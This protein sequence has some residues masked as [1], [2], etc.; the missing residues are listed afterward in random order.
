M[1]KH[2]YHLFLIAALVL[3]LVS[4]EFETSNNG[5]L[6]G[7]WQLTEVDTLHTGGIKDMKDLQIFYAIQM[8]LINVSAF[9][10]PNM[11]DNYYFH[12]E[13]RGDSLIFKTAN[14]EGKTMYTTQQLQPFGLNKEAEHFKI[15]SL[16]SNNMILQSEMLLLKFRKF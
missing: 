12:F 11:E 16:S 13:H 10:N 3:T 1:K 5:N 6:D 4:C 8:R 15:I 2:F 7:N 9:N 14:S